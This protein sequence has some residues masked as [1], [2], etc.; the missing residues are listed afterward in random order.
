VGR[1]VP[2]EVISVSGAI[3]VSAGGFHTCII[4]ALK[5]VWCWGYNRYGQLG[6]SNTSDS[7]I[8]VEVVGLNSDVS[9]VSLGRFHS[10]VI[11]ILSQLYCWGHNINGQLGL[12]HTTDKSIPTMVVFDNGH[13]VQVSLG[14]YHSCIVNNL[15]QVWCWGANWY[16]VLGDGTTTTRTTPTQTSLTTS[17]SKIDVGG[18]HSCAVDNRSDLYCWGG[19]Y[20]GQLGLGTIS[21]LVVLPTKVTAVDDVVQ[22]SA[23]GYSTLLVDGNDNIMSMGRNNYGQL[24]LGDTTNRNTPTLLT[25]I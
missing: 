2:K 20:Y 10:C 1:N 19:N 9:D 25:G 4:S 3:K 18:Y 13:A 16:G 8:P 7:N 5:R 24:G 15:S 6:T 22:V 23:G 11:D 21:Y 14:S 12:G 17:A